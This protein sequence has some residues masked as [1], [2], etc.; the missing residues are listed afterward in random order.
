MARCLLA[1]DCTSTI[2]LDKIGQDWRDGDWWTGTR[3]VLDVIEVCQ[4]VAV[5]ILEEDPVP[6]GYAAVNTEPEDGGQMGLPGDLPEQEELRGLLGG[7][8]P[9]VVV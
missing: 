6:A 8:H 7:H 3:P 1:A 9:L 4:V 2:L 5:V